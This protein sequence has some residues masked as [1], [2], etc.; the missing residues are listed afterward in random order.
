PE[1]DESVANEIGEKIKEGV[2]KLR[3]V[4]SRTGVRLP[5][6]TISVGVNNFKA[7]QNVNAVISKTRYSIST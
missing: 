2:A 4:S 5:Q 7:S 6:M 1:V 3:F